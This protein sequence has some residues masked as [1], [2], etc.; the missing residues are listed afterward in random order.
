MKA[1]YLMQGDTFTLP[2][3]PGRTFTATM[4]PWRKGIVTVVITATRDDGVTVELDMH[5]DDEVNRVVRFG[6]CLACCSRV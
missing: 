3:A 6:R 5:P 4:R 1:R 2:L